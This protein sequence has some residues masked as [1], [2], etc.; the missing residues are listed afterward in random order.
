M[1]VNFLLIG[2]I[3]GALIIVVVVGL[4]LAFGNR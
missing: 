4:V 1:A 2:G 3:A